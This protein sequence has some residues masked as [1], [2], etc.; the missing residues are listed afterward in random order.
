MGKV[1]GG[2]GTFQLSRKGSAQVIILLAIPKIKT[3]ESKKFMEINCEDLVNIGIIYQDV[4]TVITRSISGL[5]PIWVRGMGVHCTYDCSPIGIT[6]E[7]HHRNRN[8][9][10]TDKEG[11]GGG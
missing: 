8:D 6:H 5:H 2:S 1:P 9:I 3:G 7:F 10:T 4:H 11:G